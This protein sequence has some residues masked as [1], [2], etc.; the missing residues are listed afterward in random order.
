[1]R[2]QETS[3]GR[4]RALQNIFVNTYQ[5][6]EQYMILYDSYPACILVYTTHIVWS[7][8][9]GIRH[10]TYIF[11]VKIIIIALSYIFEDILIFVHI[12]STVK[13]ISYTIDLQWDKFLW[14]TYTQTQQITQHSCKSTGYYMGLQLN[15]NR[16]FSTISRFIW[17]VS[18][19]EYII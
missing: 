2:V 14:Q 17:N 16:L 19:P 9:N 10:N 12:R 5:W 8:Q 1:M 11:Q 6:S 18:F 7:K 3:R 13:H 4:Q 15:S